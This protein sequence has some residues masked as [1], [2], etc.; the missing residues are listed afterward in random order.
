MKKQYRLCN[1]IAAIP[2]YGLRDL[3]RRS[4][5]NARR[6][7]HCT[8]FGVGLGLSN[9]QAALTAYENHVTRS[10]SLIMKNRQC[11][12]SLGALSPVD[13]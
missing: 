12:E 1:S 6:C 11:I 8:A 7:Y 10:T 5:T 13:R 3:H 4:L 9:Q 2:R